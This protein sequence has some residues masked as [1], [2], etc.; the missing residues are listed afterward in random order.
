MGDLGAP[1]CGFVRPIRATRLAKICV[2]ADEHARTTVISDDLVEIAVSRLTQRADRILPVG[3]EGMVLKIQ[4][5]DL[6]VGRNG[7][8]A[9]LPAGPEKLQSGAVVELWIIKFRDR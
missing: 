6:G 8:D 3:L 2:R 7:V 9:L 4:G 5:Y 1:N